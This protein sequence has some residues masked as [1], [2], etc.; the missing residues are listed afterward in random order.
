M[1][2]VRNPGSTGTVA[3]GY[4]CG[5]TESMDTQT[6]Q[7]GLLQKVK[8]SDLGRLYLESMGA[9]SN[10]EGIGVQLGLTYNDTKVIQRDHFIN[11]GGV[12]GC[13][14]M[15]L[16]LAIQKKLLKTPK[17]LS[18]ALKDDEL[19]A[20]A[21]DFDKKMRQPEVKFQA[22]TNN[23]AEFLSR[24]L[25]V[26]TFKDVAAKWYVLG[27]ILKVNTATLDEIE[28]DT[29]GGCQ[30][31]CAQMLRTWIRDRGSAAT[32][33][34]LTHYL[35]RLELPSVAD[36][37][38]RSLNSFSLPADTKYTAP[39][40]TRPADDDGE[41]NRCIAQLPGTK[42]ERITESENKIAQLE[43]TVAEL[44]SKQEEAANN[45]QRRISQL[46]EI[47]GVICSN[48]QFIAGLDEQ[49]KSRIPEL[50]KR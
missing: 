43:A 41:D 15:T 10:W 21:S 24:G 17:D 32:I 25:P 39:R 30:E 28:N 22:S 14:L 20:C 47:L 16:K 1:F 27:V 6:G 5:L 31:M 3:G 4:N 8:D 7:D 18:Q 2:N 26:S 19:F 40:Q 9:V 36:N 45:A 33:S 50:L 29:R 38:S 23:D 12:Q 44:K 48:P 13:Y 11:S 34:E 42:N 49:K 37:I 35:Y 46:T